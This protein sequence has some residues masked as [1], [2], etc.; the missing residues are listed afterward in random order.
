M[1][2][3]LLRTVIVDEIMSY[4]KVKPKSRIQF[5]FRP[6]PKSELNQTPDIKPVVTQKNTNIVHSYPSSTNNVN[7]NQKPLTGLKSFLE[8]TTKLEDSVER[9]PCEESS[10]DSKSDG[11]FERKHSE[12]LQQL[13]DLQELQE[14]HKSVLF[15]GV[16]KKPEDFPLS[17]KVKDEVKGTDVYLKSSNDVEMRSA[18]SSSKGE[19]LQ[20]LNVEIKPG[21]V[22]DI[23]MISAKSAGRDVTKQHE[24]QTQNNN[25]LP[26][27]SLAVISQEVTPQKPVDT[28]E[29]IRMALLSKERGKQR[30]GDSQTKSTG[31]PV[32]A[33]QKQREREEKRRQ[34]LEKA[35][36]R[37]KKE[38]K[39]MLLWYIITL[40][41]WYYKKIVL[42][43]ESWIASLLEKYASV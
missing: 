40:R 10:I 32:T 31:K 28:K 3:P 36:Q 5:D 19:N 26:S 9:Q 42:F 25:V 1:S 15:D 41:T 29:L 43:L 37:K 24:N 38:K 16:F 23:E 33:I 30:E 2:T 18:I 13:K 27:K 17:V 20:L 8:N 6:V 7:Q 35:R 4:H 11:S 34:K 21:E 39:G 22:S 12:L 14:P